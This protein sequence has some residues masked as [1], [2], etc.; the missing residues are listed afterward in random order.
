MGGSM[1]IHTFGAYFG[2]AVASIVSPREARRELPPNQ[3]AKYNSDLFS[4]IGTIWLWMLWPS[5]NGALAPADSQ[6]RVIINT[7]TSL[8]GC[9]VTT[10]FM[11]KLLRGKFEMEDVQ[12]A[13]VAGGV[14]VG[15]ASD[16]VI[17]PG[18]AL[19]IGMIAA[20][21][22]AI[23]FRFLSPM[24]RKCY[25]HDTCGVNNLHG[26]PGILGGLTGA[27]SSAVAA[28]RVSLYGT[29]YKTIFV[30][31]EVQWGY[32]LLALVITIAIAITSGLGTGL[33]LRFMH[34][35]KRI[36][37]DAEYWAVPDDEW[38]PDV[39]DRDHPTEVIE[40]P[41][42]P[43]Q[44]DIELESEPVHGN[45]VVGIEENPVRTITL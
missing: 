3:G 28:R 15:A 24:L 31:G 34:A 20:M 16:L 42:S 35:P 44:I 38:L 8:L 27:V 33:L 25:I 37:T 18:G 29:D 32:Q 36:F 39:D 12:N 21:I 10:F 41:M 23:G 30:R 14:A 2:I 22:S 7:V 11:S 45:D 40:S 43:K 1:F 13:S 26:L 5:F 19:V 17:S 6:F 9:V 4:I